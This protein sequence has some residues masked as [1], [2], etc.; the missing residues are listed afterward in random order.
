MGVKMILTKLIEEG[1]N[2]TAVSDEYYDYSESENFGNGVP[3]TMKL[4]I[5]MILMMLM[6]MMMMMLM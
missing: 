4:L 1:N 5:K 6:M 2:Y 3:I